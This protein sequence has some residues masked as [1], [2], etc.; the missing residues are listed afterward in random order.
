MK[1]LFCLVLS[2]GF[3]VLIAGNALAANAPIRAAVVPQVVTISNTTTGW[4]MI[5]GTGTVSAPISIVQVS[6]NTGT[7]TI[8]FATQNS[9]TAWG[10][11]PSSQYGP[12]YLKMISPD[13]TNNVQGIYLA[14]TVTAGPSAVSVVVTK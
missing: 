9:P 6:C 7:E 12:L 1:K 4:T 8:L 14:K 11:W 2:F 10:I 13:K 5:P 3:Y